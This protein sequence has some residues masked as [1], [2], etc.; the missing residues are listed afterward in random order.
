MTRIDPFAVASRASGDT[1]PE[2]VTGGDFTCV[3]RKIV[4][5]SPCHNGWFAPYLFLGSVQIA[6]SMIEAIVLRASNQ[7]LSE[8]SAHV[9]SSFFPSLVGRG[10]VVV[11]RRRSCA[12][13][14]RA[15]A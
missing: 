14:R 8:G 10:G 13:G 5:P 2:S 11:A 12:V 6:M 15:G 1:R 4:F 3:S 9:S 7:A